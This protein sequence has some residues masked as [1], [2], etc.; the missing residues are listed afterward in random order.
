M[1]FF[2]YNS[3]CLD[4]KPHKCIEVEYKV[5][6]CGHFGTKYMSVSITVL[7]I[8]HVETC[9]DSGEW[10]SGAVSQ[11][12]CAFYDRSMKL[13]VVFL[14]TMK[15]DFRR[16]NTSELTSGT[17]QRSNQI[18]PPSAMMKIHLFVYTHAKPLF[19]LIGAWEIHFWYCF[20]HFGLSWP[21][22]VMVKVI[23]PSWRPWP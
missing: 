10:Y 23:L 14:Y 4:F 1:C 9:T 16:G 3:K 22:K 13:S 11:T 8:Q 2:L 18:W 6:Y 21:W 17:G 5:G 19:W 12:Y 20:E 7:E 15:F